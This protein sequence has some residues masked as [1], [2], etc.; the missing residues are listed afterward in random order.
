[1]QN[2]KLLLSIK[3]CTSN[4]NGYTVEPPVIEDPKSQVE[5]VT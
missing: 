4:K 3:L 5:V 2:T 1:M